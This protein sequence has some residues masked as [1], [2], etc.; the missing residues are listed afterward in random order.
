MTVIARIRTRNV[1]L[2]AA[3]RGTAGVLRRVRCRYLDGMGL[4]WRQLDGGV[5]RAVVDRGRLMPEQVDSYDD[6]REPVP[7]PT[8]VMRRALVHEVGLGRAYRQARHRSSPAQSELGR[9]LTEGRKTTM[10]A[11]TVGLAAVPHSNEAYN[12]T[13]FVSHSPHVYSVVEYFLNVEP[14]TGHER[15]WKLFQGNPEVGEA[16]SAH[17]MDRVGGLVGQRG[18]G[19]SA[20]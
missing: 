9:P 12:L 15:F 11:E 3:V 17:R 10:S 14:N 20:R 13:R 19:G 6:L 16:R 4:Q 2:V 1:E 7:W 8:P 5:A 18:A